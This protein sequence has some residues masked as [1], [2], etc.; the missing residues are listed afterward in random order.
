LV[1]DLW[2]RGTDCI[3]DDRITDVDTKSQRFKDPH[4]VL[5]A[6]EREKKTK[7]LEACLEHCTHFSPFVASTDGLLGD[8]VPP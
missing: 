6:D 8:M 5:E 2:A 7:Y 3:I 1:Q 4:K